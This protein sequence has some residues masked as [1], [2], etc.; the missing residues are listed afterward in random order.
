MIKFL[1]ISLVVYIG[2]CLTLIYWPIPEKKM[3]EN[4]DY[5]SLKQSTQQKEQGSEQSVTLRDGKALFFRLY[6]AD[7]DTTLILLHGSGSESR[8]LSQLASFLAKNGTMRVITPDLRGHG[9]NDGAR[10]D[11]DYI[12]QLDHDI[13]DLFGYVKEHYA[14]TRIVLGGHSS[15]GGMALRYVGNKSVPQ[16]DGLLLIAPY[17]GHKA[18]TVKPNSGEW[19][20]VALK[21]WIGLEMINRLGFSAL[22]GLPVLLFNRPES[23]N[24]SL[25]VDSYSYRMAVNFAPN[26]YLED[27]SSISMPALVLVGENDESFYPDKFSEVF[28]DTKQHIDIHIVD[29]ANH[30][31]IVDAGIS[32]KHLVDWHIKSK[33]K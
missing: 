24:D 1:F 27:I 15:G 31:N 28:D 25:Q 13:E 3:V 5:S 19:V 30:M 11:I 18:P 16:P 29:S 10:G 9:R 17:L 6:E 26:N 22:N 12:G 20:T 23:W 2:I 7:S 4:Y 21:R 33:A 14:G 32:G 8:Y